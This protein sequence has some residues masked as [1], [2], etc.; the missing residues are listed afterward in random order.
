[1]HILGLANGTVGGNSE[2]LLKAAL[3]AA[4]EADPSTTISWI[5]VPSVV[6]PT[7][8]KARDLMDPLN[9]NKEVTD[10]HNSKSSID[11]RSH[12]INAIM[13]ADALLFATPVYS[14]LPAGALKVLFD[15]IGSMST[16][17]PFVHRVVEA[18]RMGQNTYDGMH[19]DRRVLKTRVAAFIVVA[20]SVFSDQMTMALPT[21]HQ[22]VF[23]FHAKVVDQHIFKGYGL[24]GTVLLDQ[25]AIERAKSLGKN[26]ASQMGK[27]FDDA[28][29]LGGT[30]RNSCPYC[31]LGKIELIEETETGVSCITCA[32][33]GTMRV[34]NDGQIDL[35]WE[36]PSTNSFHTINGL[37]KHGE[38]SLTAP[39]E[40]IANIH[41]VE[42]KVK[43]WAGI[44][45]PKA[46]LASHS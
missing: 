44:E 35:V 20:G 46:K 45:M 10:I 6:I 14:H 43:F 16:S 8:S 32:A 39:L 18:E 12:I 36:V 2:I 41:L 4:Q 28:R 17:F 37:L 29:Y 40:E 13:D 22:F 11:D 30:E 42:D 31:H 7:K 3:T 34:G 19:I 38:E 24:P 21:M 9:A 23:P 15:R 33:R 5:H 1:M 27:S 26:L 25:A